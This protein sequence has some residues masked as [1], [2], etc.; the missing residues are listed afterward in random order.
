MSYSYT[1]GSSETRN[2]N[3]ESSL[4]YDDGKGYIDGYIPGYTS[5][6]YLFSET[7]DSDISG[8]FANPGFGSA[9]FDQSAVRGEYYGKGEAAFF[10]D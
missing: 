4:F 6:E 2:Y 8:S 7:I 10:R 1:A 5:N 3:G 9:I